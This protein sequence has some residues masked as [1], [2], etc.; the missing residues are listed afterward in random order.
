MSM[1]VPVPSTRRHSDVNDAAIVRVSLTPDETLSL[2]L[3]DESRDV[4]RTHPEKLGEFALG[5]AAALQGG[6]ERHVREQRKAARPERGS[7]GRHR[8]KDHPAHLADGLL[9]ELG[10]FL[11]G[12]RSSTAS[13]SF[14]KKV[15]SRTIQ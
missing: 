9:D 14:L 3:I 1:E 13:R 2:Q 11:V 15:P 5:H 8:P 4:G 10:A 6:V 12:H 7:E